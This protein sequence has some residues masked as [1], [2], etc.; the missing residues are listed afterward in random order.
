MQQHKEDLARIVTLKSGEPFGKVWEKLTTA[1]PISITTNEGHRNVRTRHSSS[2]LWD[3]RRSLFIANDSAVWLAFYFCTIDLSRAFRF[4]RRSVQM[5][6][7]LNIDCVRVHSPSMDEFYLEVG[8]VAIDDDMFSSAIARFGGVRRARSGSRSTWRPITFTWMCKVGY[9]RL[10]VVK[11][12]GRDLIRDDLHD[13]PP[14]F[15]RQVLLG[16]IDGNSLCHGCFGDGKELHKF[17]IHPWKAS[18]VVWF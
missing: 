13:I 6:L 11:G 7:G 5:R 16:A 17:G 12:V 9:F 4:A 15:C 18:F 2:S 3:K 14:H 1:Q 10:L 8:I